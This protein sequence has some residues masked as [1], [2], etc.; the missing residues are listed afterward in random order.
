MHT[1]ENAQLDARCPLLFVEAGCWVSKPIF[2]A[3]YSI[4]FL[5]S[6][7]DNGWLFLPTVYIQR[8]VPSGLGQ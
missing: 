5:R 8:T 2:N 1:Q 7:A 4:F 3:L 6:L